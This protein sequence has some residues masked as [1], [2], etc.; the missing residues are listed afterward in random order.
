MSK[1]N[2]F[3]TK[4]HAT[5]EDFCCTDGFENLKMDRLK[6]N[7]SSNKIEAQIL[8]NYILC[9]LKAQTYTDTDH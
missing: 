1:Y 8:Q 6:D 2:C 5:L 4:L 3:K 9:A 7:R